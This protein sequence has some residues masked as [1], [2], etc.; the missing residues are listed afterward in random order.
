MKL[1]TTQASA[2][3]AIDTSR[4]YLT[5]NGQTDTKGVSAPTVKSLR[6]AGLVVPNGAA[7]VTVKGRA[8][9]RLVLTPAG[10]AAR[11]Q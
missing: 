5:N 8:A 2:L 11:S 9:R 10:R 6:T 3:L 7:R 4:V 1:S